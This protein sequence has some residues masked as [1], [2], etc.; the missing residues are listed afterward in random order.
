MRKSSAQGG[1]QPSAEGPGLE[2]SGSPYPKQETALD[3]TAKAAPAPPMQRRQHLSKAERRKLAEAE[4]AEFQRQQDR[5]RLL[6]KVK[7]GGWVAL[8][9]TLI[10]FLSLGLIRLM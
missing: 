4:E 9:A 1:V 3:K 5:E 2:T 10:V 8:T 6:R 7:Q